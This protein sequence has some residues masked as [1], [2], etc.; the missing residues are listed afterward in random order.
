MPGVAEKITQIGLLGW[1]CG[2]ALL[3]VATLS[4][5]ASP[6]QR[7]G[8]SQGDA[9]IAVLGVVAQNKVPYAGKRLQMA[10]Y[11]EEF[12]TSDGRFRHIP[13]RAVRENLSGF[14]DEVLNEYSR[15]GDL[16]R[17]TIA[18]LAEAGAVSGASPD[19]AVISR[20]DKNVVHPKSNKYTDEMQTITEVR[21]NQG[22]VLQDR[23]L[24]TLS[25][26]RH[27]AVTTTVY[28]IQS[29]DV[30]WSKSFESRP[31]TTVSRIDYSGS[32]FAGA[33][34]AS[35]ANLFSNGTRRFALPAPPGEN[36]A[37]REAFREVVFHLS[38]G[39]DRI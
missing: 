34:T 9:T 13:Y 11:L 12:L 15:E 3:L 27:V 2:I 26:E 22:L 4:S 14:H 39:P 35:V 19:Y 5:C 8:W 21:D 24:I 25:R 31:R 38:K 28:D 23:R 29:G 10:G 37:L 36:L 7:L 17:Q 6:G 20:V 18:L 16:S 30:V 32:S 33:V 1:R